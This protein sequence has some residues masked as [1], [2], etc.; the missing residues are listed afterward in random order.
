MNPTA[1]A[2]GLTR[3]TVNLVPASVA[4]LDRAAELTGDSKTDIVNRALQ[5]YTLIHDVADYGHGTMTIDN[6]LLTIR[7]TT[8]PPTATRRVTKFRFLG[9]TWTID[10]SWWRRR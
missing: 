9:S 8:P 4:A 5:A 10:T 1:P 6:V 2:E 3:M 7:D